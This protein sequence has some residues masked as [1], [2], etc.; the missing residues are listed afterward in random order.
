MSSHFQNDLCS[1]EVQA[2]ETIR[3]VGPVALARIR[4]V[5]ACQRTHINTVFP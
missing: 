5:S 3:A 4:T 1:K 2:L